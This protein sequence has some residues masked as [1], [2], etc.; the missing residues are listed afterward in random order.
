MCEIGCRLESEG[1]VS[2]VW[3]LFGL[4]EDEILVSVCVSGDGWEGY[5]LFGMKGALDDYVN[6]ESPSSAHEFPP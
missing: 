4:L 5:V 2:G 1:V 6:S 3:L